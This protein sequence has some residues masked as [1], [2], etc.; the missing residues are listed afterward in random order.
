MEQLYKK[1]LE[2]MGEDPQREGL[3]R[4]PERAA[5]AMAFLT[6]GYSQSLETIIN[7][8]IFH[9]DMDEMVIVKDIEF[10]SLCEHHLLPFFG[11]CHVAYLPSGKI[12]GLSKVARI[13]DM[14]A[15]RLQVQENLTSQIAKSLQELTDAKGIGVVMEASHLCM[16]MRGVE[17]QNSTMTTSYMLGLFRTNAS[18]RSEFLN[19]ISSRNI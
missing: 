2:E 14:Y 16:K 6:R 9:S 3:Q 18:T 5:K 15:R 19:L 11:K 8:A 1:L 13:V 4:T 10:F 7:G 12:I 17:K